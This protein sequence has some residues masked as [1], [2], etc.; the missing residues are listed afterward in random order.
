MS[1]NKKILI[2]EDNLDL[3]HYLET[4]LQNQG[5]LTDVLTRGA[6]T[7]DYLK[8]NEPDLVLLDLKLPDIKGESLCRQI[9]EMY[10]HIP[11]IILTAKDNIQNIVEGFNLGAEDYITKPFDNEELLA[12]IKARLKNNQTGILKVA[13]LKLNTQTKEVSRQDKLIDL[14]KTEFNL[15][16][17]L[18]TNKN[19]VLSRD[20]I[21]NHV[22]GYQDETNTRVVDVYIGYLRKKI[23]QEFDPKLIHSVRGFG[24]MLS[25]K[26]H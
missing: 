6:K 23:D 10:N 14:T 5:F 12:R 16:K 4:F 19:Q 3:G 8:N 21:L 15:L 9:N 26:R 18:L 2:V 1:D 17:Y 20:M 24:Y 25:D 22:W 13:D 7:L 11:V